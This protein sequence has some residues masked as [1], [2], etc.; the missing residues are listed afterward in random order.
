MN[1]KGQVQPIPVL[2]FVIRGGLVFCLNMAAGYARETYREI[3]TA[4]SEINAEVIDPPVSCAAMLARRL[5]LSEMQAMMAAGF[6]GGIGL[7][8]GGCGALGAA[9]WSS[10]L[11]DG[12]PQSNIQLTNPKI[13]ALMEKFLESSGHEFECARIVGRRFENIADHADYLRQGGCTKI[14]EALAAR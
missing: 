7:S 6:A 10:S 1:L 2:K 12:Q 9:V 11:D 3:D 5:G 8:G 4:L 13:E 14:L